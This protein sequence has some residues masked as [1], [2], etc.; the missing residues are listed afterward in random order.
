MINL[1]TIPDKINIIKNILKEYETAKRKRIPFEKIWD[2]CQKYT[3]P[4]TN[5]NFDI[6]DSTASNAA[7]EL[8][9]S[10]LS[11]LSSP[12]KDWFS[13][14][15]QNF[16][17]DAAKQELILKT[18]NTLLNILRR[19]NF[20]TEIHQCYLDLVVFGTCVLKIQTMPVGSKIP[21]MF[22]AIPLSNIYLKEDSFGTLNKVFNKLKINTMDLLLN[23]PN[24]LE[25]QKVINTLDRAGDNIDLTEAVIPYR[26]KMGE[27]GY[28]YVLFYAPTNPYD[29]AIIFDY[30]KLS[31]SPFV[32]ARWLY[33][34]GEIYGFSPVM[35]SLP[36]I[37]TANKVVELALKNASI[38]VAGVWMAED[39]GVIDL[40]N[41]DLS[42]GNII[43]KAAGSSGLTPLKT[44]ADFNVSQLVLADLRHNINRSLLTEEFHL[45]NNMQ[46]ATEIIT[47]H[48]RLSRILGATYGRIQNELLNPII[49]NLV[50][51]LQ[52]Q[53]I[54]E[55]FFK[56]GY[57][58]DFKYISPILKNQNIRDMEN[59]FRWFETAKS[60]GPQGLE[61][62][63]TKEL[64]KYMA[65][66]LSVPDNLV[67]KNV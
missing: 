60:L 26:G 47:K 64:L 1:T 7:F 31:K 32:C 39:D 44:G 12:T 25:N 21:V 24:I 23:F 16:N 54:I 50:A 35:K 2:D 8:T 48:Q 49:E 20:Y 17:D 5:S 18:K 41:I 56:S 6:Y 37:K 30:K 62:V 29:E 22:R 58:I 11:E 66:N 28:H 33:N 40:N 42:P 63:N 34:A 61:M 3:L 57:E 45:L 27:F 59:I 53:G 10:L 13:L 15:I 51:F 55:N 46:T 52:T 9:G 36:D 65:Q 14:D 38:S 4:S 43:L 19:S 67:N